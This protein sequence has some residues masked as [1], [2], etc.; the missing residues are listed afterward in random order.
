MRT[1]LFFLF[2]RKTEAAQKNLTKKKRT[3][4]L[5]FFLTISLFL[6]CSSPPQGYVIL[7]AGDSITEQGYTRFLQRML[8]REGIRARVLNYGK[9]GYTSGEYLNFLKENE[10]ELAEDRP[11]FILVQL[12]TNDVREDY[13]STSARQF[14]TQ[15][16]EIISIFQRFRSRS[17]KASRIFL[18]LIPPIPE[19]IP[20]PFTGNSTKRVPREINPLIHQICTEEHV[21]LVDNYSLFLGSPHLL[22]EIHPSEQGYRALAQ[23]WF[24]AL[25]VHMKP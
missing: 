14:Y 20:F 21:S 11:D 24:E 8:N 4:P 17:D 10:S 7:C 16:K 23:N 15:M 1:V 2:F 25:K 3:V 18:A 9:S 19:G 6:S 22:P 12:G 5:F 13:D